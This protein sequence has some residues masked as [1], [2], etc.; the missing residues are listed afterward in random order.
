MSAE[1]CSNKTVKFNL[2]GLHSFATTNGLAIKL[3]DL[4]KISQLFRDCKTTNDVIV[5]EKV[6]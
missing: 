6:N 4:L 2:G 5:L 3:D 1:I